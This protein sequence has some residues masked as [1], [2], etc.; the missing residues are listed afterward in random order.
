MYFRVWFCIV[1]MIIE[2]GYFIIMIV[3]L[4]QYYQPKDFE[5]NKELIN[6]T[7]Q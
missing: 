1:S 6:N 2:K 4:T 7:K 3:L 5:A